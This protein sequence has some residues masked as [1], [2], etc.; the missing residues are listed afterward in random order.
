MS[1]G[2]AAVLAGILGAVIGEFVGSDS[3]L[4][5]FIIQRNAQLQTADVF[6]A[7][8][9]LSLMGIALFVLVG[10]VD[11]LDALLLGHLKDLAAVDGDHDGGAL[12]VLGLGDGVRDA[13]A[14][15]G[16]QAKQRC[17]QE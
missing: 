3:G 8:V 13:G 11:V 12:L 15:G 1:T 7:I 16:S 5:S 14:Q 4:G 6:A 2:L 10:V 9:T 17:I